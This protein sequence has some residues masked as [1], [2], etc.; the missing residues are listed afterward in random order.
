MLA[1]GE[2]VDFGSFARR[3]LTNFP[4][5]SIGVYGLII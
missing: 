2:A 4:A 1:H 5:F 3:L